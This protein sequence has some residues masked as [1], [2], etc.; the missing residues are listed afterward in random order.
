MDR[1]DWLKR[2]GLLAEERG[3]SISAHLD[4]CPDCQQYHAQINELRA[5]LGKIV[6]PGPPERWQQLVWQRID[7]SA[8]AARRRLVLWF[9]L[10]VAA[11]AALLIFVMR[12]REEPAGPLLAVTFEHDPQRPRT[13]G[14]V[15]VG[16]AVR[17]S[18]TVREPAELRVYREGAL[19]F[20]CAGPPACERRGDQLSLRWTIPA[21]GRYRVIL[22]AASAPAPKSSLDEDAAAA[23]AA[24]VLW[25]ESDLIEIW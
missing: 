12:P 25:R 11:A 21:V 6:V 19:A 14:D 23:T 18:A 2:E 15:A 20:R 3:E 7:R 22:A 1:C 13:R 24:G 5:D 10:P 16:D 4:G 9:A 8:S 17:V